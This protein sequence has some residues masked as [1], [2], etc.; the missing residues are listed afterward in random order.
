ML[1]E[2]IT[3][4]LLLRREA[5]VLPLDENGA[6]IVDADRPD[7]D[8]LLEDGVDLQVETAL[9]LLQSQRNARKITAQ[10]EN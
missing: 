10:R 9:V 4:S 3:E 1:P 6:I 7:P 5:D 8:S 2:Q